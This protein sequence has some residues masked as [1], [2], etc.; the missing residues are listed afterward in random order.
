MRVGGFA[1][2]SFVL[3]VASGL[4]WACT[5]SEKTAPKPKAIVSA[6]P[7]PPPTKVEGCPKTGSM[8][9]IERDPSCVVEQSEIGSMRDPLKN[10]KLT[11]TPNHDTIVT[12]GTGVLQLTIT[13]TGASDAMIIFEAQPPGVGVRPDWTRLMGVPEPRAAT[14][15]TFHLVFPTRTLDSKDRVVDALPVATSQGPSRLF[16]VRLKAGGSLSHVMSWWALR[17]PAPYP[18]YRDDAGHR[19]VPKTAPVTLPP[20]EYGVSLEVPFFGVSAPERTVTAR[21]HVVPVDAGR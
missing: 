21:M 9:A 2:A 15:E 11:L 8:D 14:T 5:E 17:I 3:F 13:N 12:G 20:G 16:R 7:D 6:D 4:A 19:I 1:R 18:I 10:L